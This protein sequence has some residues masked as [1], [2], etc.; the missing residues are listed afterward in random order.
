MITRTDLVEWQLRVAQGEKLPLN[1]DQIKI[2]GHAFEGR[3][4][5]EDPN[6]N[7]MPGAGKLKYLKTPTLESDGS[8]R[9]ETGV[10][11][12]DEVSVHYDPLIAKLVC[13]SKDRKSALRKLRS[14]LANYQIAGFIE[15]FKSK[16]CQLFNR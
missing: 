10:E 12:G 15:R 9:V 6:A 14:S 13:W 7:F 11:Q 2:H 8:I 3:I 16:K 4:Y 5:A 1:Q